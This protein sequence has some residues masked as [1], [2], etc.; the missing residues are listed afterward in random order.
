M[1]D[2]SHLDLKNS[3]LDIL[4]TMFQEADNLYEEM[5]EIRRDLHMHPELSFQEIRTPKIISDHLKSLDLEVTENVGGNGVV[6]RLKGGQPGPTVAF[7]AD[8][9]ALPMNDEKE[10]PYK[11]TV[12]GAVHAC[13]HDLHTSALMAF[14]K[15][16]VKYKHLL[17]GTVVF[18]HQHA[19][20]LP[21]GGA[22]AMIKDGVLEGVDFIYGAHVWDEGAVGE[23]G[24]NSGYTMGGGDNFEITVRG[25]GG[26]GAMPHLTVDSLVA[27]SQLVVNL[28]QILSRRLDPKESGVVTI[29][30]FNS[31][32]TMNAIADKAVI[33][34]T[35]RCF[36]NETKLKIRKW[37]HHISETTAEQF[38]AECDI[39]FTYGYDS[40]F[41][42][43]TETEDLRILTEKYSKTLTPV[44]KPSALLGE[45]FSYYLQEVPG[46]FFFA[47]GRNEDINAVYPHHHPKF[48]MDEQSMISICRVFLLAA[49]KHLIEG[50]L[51]A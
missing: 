26:H 7:R 37:I 50:D 30:T 48:D 32:T 43:E 23:V 46:T 12:P 29:G 3:T 9:D 49:G 2:T 38:G 18:I 44:A 41:N 42:H 51:D 45:D 1:T 47:G 21:P 39:D 16:L 27:A 36:N 11:S 35:S 33:T 22:K 19:E 15:I 14:E 4:S 5:V 40:L 25:K 17:K 10:V 20:E 31:G 34:G 13:G 28:Q 6:G 24:F 8:F